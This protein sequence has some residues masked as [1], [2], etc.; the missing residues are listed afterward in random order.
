MKT[1]ISHILLALLCAPV[2]SLTASA[3]EQADTHEYVDLGLTSGTLWATCNVGADSP[4]AY[5]SYFAWG[6]VTTKASYL[7]TNYAYCS[8]TETTITKYCADSSHGTVDN[9]TILDPEDDAAVVNWGASWCMPTYE[10]QDELRKECTWT[11]TTVNGKAGYMVESKKNG[12]SIFMPA[13][14]NYGTSLLRAG[15]DGYYWSRSLITKTSST[16]Y[17]HYFTSSEN[18]YSGGT[19]YVGRPVRAIRAEYLSAASD[20]EVLPDQSIELP[21]TMTNTHAISGLQFDL[22]LPTGFTFEKAT[23]SADRAGA[24]HYRVSTEKLA[25]G[26]VR[27]VCMSMSETNAVFSGNDGAVLTLTITTQGTARP[28][29]YT[30]TLRDQVLTT[31]DL[32]EILP[33]PTT[34]QISVVTEVLG[35]GEVRCPAPGQLSTVLGTDCTHIKI[36]GDL[37][38]TDIKYIR[39]LIIDHQLTSLDLEDANIVAGGEAYKDTEVTQ[40]NVVGKSMFH[41]CKKLTSLTLPTSITKIGLFALRFSGVKSITIPANVTTI[42]DGFAWGAAD[43]AEIIVAE[44]NTHFTVMDNVL[45]TA[46]K[47]TLH[48]CPNAKS[49]EFVVPDGITQIGSRAFEGCS[50][51]TTITIPATV[52]KIGGDAFRE[53]N[54][55]ED[56]ICAAATP[57]ALPTAT[58]FDG[59]T[60]A[61]AVLHVPQASLAAY[62][63]ADFWKDFTNIVS[64]EENA[65]LP[66][67]DLVLYVG[68]TAPM[69]LPSYYTDFFILTSSNPEVCTIS[70]E[71]VITGVSKGKAT[72]QLENAQSGTPIATCEVTV[73]NIG[74]QLKGDVNTDGNV[75][76]SD[77]STLVDILLNKK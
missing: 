48:T 25:D 60:K 23:V 44:G 6:E 61:N 13:A 63:A 14:G 68:G 45:Y 73:V 55:L 32:T 19:R 71:G 74:E 66:A 15:T 17:C 54:G 16:A 34:A 76:I 53:C 11:W 2:C 77:V 39:S 21:V 59:A 65:T 24:F 20:V 67:S 31:T 56:I 40:N 29:Q 43:L 72:I 8:G 30:I 41:S 28:G 46:D 50:K 42:T 51:L 70:P 1:Y 12:N 9:K 62:R 26:A 69:M 47:K 4:E 57:P 38:G 33:Q 35:E 58:P 7:W 64:I 52:T 22:V 75:S 5:G 27:I 10:Q 36:Y 18:R 3:D 37:N 49:G